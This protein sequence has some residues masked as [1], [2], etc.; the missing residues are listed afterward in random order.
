MS[1][2]VVKSVKSVYLLMCHLIEMSWVRLLIK[3]HLVT[4]I[5]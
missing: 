4:S 3:H 2:L 5:D 1:R